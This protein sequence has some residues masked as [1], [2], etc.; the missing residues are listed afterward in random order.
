VLLFDLYSRLYNY[1]LEFIFEA[2]APTTERDFVKLP[3]ERAAIYRQIQNS[4]M[5]A[6]PDGPWFF[7]RGAQ[8]R[9]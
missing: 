9:H 1:P 7:Y 3:P 8:C 4:F 2:L 6:S 5:H